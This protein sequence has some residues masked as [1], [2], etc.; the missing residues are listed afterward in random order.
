MLR[1]ASTRLIWRKKSSTRAF[2]TKAQEEY[3]PDVQKIKYEGPGTTNPFAFREYNPDEVVY[4]KTMRE[5][6]RFSVCYWH[7]FS[8]VGSDPFGSGTMV[9]PWLTKSH[10]PMQTALHK[11]DAAFEFFG[12]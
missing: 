9:R 10:D 8:S 5:W 11:A 1:R 4:G 2:S 3:F 7:S 6:C 12:K